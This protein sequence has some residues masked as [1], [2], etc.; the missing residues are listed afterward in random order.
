MRIAVVGAGVTGLATA[1]ELAASGHQITVF[2]RRQTVAEEASY[3]GTGL[4]AHGLPWPSGRGSS[5]QAWGVSPGAHPLTR[6][7]SRHPL[8]PPEQLAQLAR[9]QRDL[10]ALGADSM[11]SRFSA[12]SV[13]PDSSKDLLVLWKDD[14]AHERARPTLDALA[15]AGLP[16][17]GLEPAQIHKLEP[18]LNPD[19]PLAR[20][21]RLPEVTVA[22]PRQVCMNWRQQA[23]ATGVRFA[24]GHTVRTL[25][26]G[27][28]VRV[29]WQTV[30]QRQGEEIFDAAVL[31][32]GGAG[33]ALLRSLGLKSGIS[34]MRGRTV[35]A[36][37]RDPLLAPRAAILDAER[38]VLIVQHGQ[39]LRVAGGFG[40]ARAQE[41]PSPAN[42]WHPLFQTLDDW[43]PGVADVR[44][45]QGTVQTWEGV[46]AVSRDGRPM[47]GATSMPGI[48][49]N[50]GHG[51]QGWALAP[52][53]ARLLEE[54]LSGKTPSLDPKLCAVER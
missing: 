11:V 31:C 41:G 13:D 29:G 33:L 24:M 21:A 6:L 25:Q 20:A 39:R 54:L 50:M 28:P 19:T 14:K 32:G 17:A 30:D 2:D 15:D 10:M 53:S 49:M 46:V 43:F 22:T 9:M 27:T 3:G 1:L 47:I 48:W 18:G 8:Q 51:T 42:A 12:T 37:L 23:L 7:F 26:P 52:G 34:L 36:A 35:V 4:N 16:L 38:Q 40:P 5:V 44:A 45:R